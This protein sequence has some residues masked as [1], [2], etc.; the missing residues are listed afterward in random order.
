MVRP[1]PTESHAIYHEIA[2]RCER[3]RVTNEG[4][5]IPWLSASK[6]VIHNGCTTGVEAFVMNIPAISYRATVNDYYD[7]GFYEL[8]NRVS[9]QCFD[10]EQLR[11][12]LQED[13]RRRRGG[14]GCKCDY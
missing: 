10:F 4:N 8:P 2:A 11:E 14:S 7:L 12:T 9:H 5:V 3:V 6:A 1:H 13:P